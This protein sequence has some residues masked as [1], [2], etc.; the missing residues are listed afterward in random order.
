MLLHSS[1]AHL[2]YTAA[3]QAFPTRNKTLR[4]PVAHI[5]LIEAPSFFCPPRALAGKERGSPQRSSGRYAAAQQSK[6]L[7]TILRILIS[8]LKNMMKRVAACACKARVRVTRVVA[9]GKLSGPRER[10]SPNALKA[11]VYPTF[12]CFFSLLHLIFTG[13]FPVSP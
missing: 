4:S 12:L 1:T 6:V 10:V 13:I 11:T 3:H 9:D 5:L 2:N 7:V 8:L